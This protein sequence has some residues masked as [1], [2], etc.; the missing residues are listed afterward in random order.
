MAGHRFSAGQQS[1]V[2]TLKALHVFAESIKKQTKSS[3]IEYRT[4]ELHKEEIR[5]AASLETSANYVTFRLGGNA[6]YIWSRLDRKLRNIIRKSTANGVTVERIKSSTGLDEFYDHYL[7]I[8]TRRGSPVHRLE[9]FQTL[10]DDKRGEFPIW[11]ARMNSQFVSGV[12]VPTFKNSINWWMNINHPKYRHLNAT[13]VLLWNLIKG[14]AEKS[15][16]FR[17]DFG[18]TRVGSSIYAFKKQ[19]AGEELGLV[20]LMD[21]KTK[22]SDPEA[23]MFKLASEIWRTLPLSISKRIGPRIIVGVTL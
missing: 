14:Q 7:R 21:T 18:R 23:P 20:D 4:D 5:R 19:W 3:F 16:D 13:S 15:D 22:L 1:S 6:E 2:D 11:V 9:F 8:Q 10:F 12:I 17:F